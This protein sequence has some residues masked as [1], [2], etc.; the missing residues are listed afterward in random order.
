MEKQMTVREIVLLYLH[1]NGFDGLYGED[2]YGDPCGCS[3]YS[4]FMECDGG[5]LEDCSPGYAYDTEKCKTCDKECPIKGSFHDYRYL[6]TAE[7]MPCGKEEKQEEKIERLPECMESQLKSAAVQNEKL[8]GLITIL[9]EVL[10]D[11]S[12]G[13]EAEDRIVQAQEMLEELKA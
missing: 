10:L 8:D 2:R 4:E 5:C 6:I 9:D 7:K 11:F 12:L 1:E 13:D 3:V